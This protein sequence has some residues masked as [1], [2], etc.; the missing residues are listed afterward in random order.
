MKEYSILSGINKILF[1]LSKKEKLL[2]FCATLMTIVIGLLTSVPV[3]IIGK[4]GD[5]LI[6]IN[7]NGFTSYNLI[8]YI[9]LFVSIYILKLLFQFINK[10]IIANIDTHSEKRITD[11]L[12]LNIMKSD[13]QDLSKLKKGTINGRVIRCVEALVE[14]KIIVFIELLPM[15][16][17]T[18][19][20]IAILFFKNQTGPGNIYIAL[21]IS[22]YVPIELLITVIQIKHQ[23]INKKKIID[24]KEEIDGKINEILGGLITIRVANAHKEEYGELGILTEER[25]KHSLKHYISL[26][27]YNAGKSFVE[28]IFAVST[29]FLCVYYI[30]KGSMSVGDIL[31]YIL[32]FAEITHP[33]KELGQI[34]NTASEKSILITHLWN[35]YHCKQDDSFDKTKLVD[36]NEKM[37]DD[38]IVIKNLSFKY[39]DAN[40]KALKNISMEIKKG[41]HIGI[42]GYSGSGKTCFARIL[43]RILHGYEGEIKYFGKHL[44]AYKRSE[45]SKTIAY[46]SHDPYIFYGTIRDNILYGLKKKVKEEDIIEAVKLAEVYDDIMAMDGQFEARVIE[47]GKNLSIGQRQKIALAR[48]MLIRPNIIVLD[49]ATSALDNISE[50]KILK[51]IDYLFPEQIRISIA[52]RYTALESC[53][54]IYVFNKGEIIFDGDLH[55]VSTLNK[56][57]RLHDIQRESGVDKWE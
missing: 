8:F 33:L 25:R 36:F 12:L 42:M 11:N 29:I 51:N 46:L 50:S 10:Y 55:E 1:F 34:L 26:A 4:I 7:K 28:A 52:H 15:I 18:I 9:S 49:E 47:S 45:L 17:T 56:L 30:G 48:L 43:I 27:W 31:V 53:D 54:K 24:D 38:S 35:L 21:F 40:K 20:A 41:Q 44:E 6:D 5:S 3:I 2:L 23:K 39:N 22:L 57:Y 19:S 13:I 16:F 14:M 32:L 37:D